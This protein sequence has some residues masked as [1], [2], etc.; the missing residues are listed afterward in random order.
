M[1]K[2]RKRD[3][4]FCKGY[5]V[6]NNKSGCSETNPD[7]FE[8]S[9]RRGP[10]NV[11]KFMYCNDC[12]GGFLN[13]KKGARLNKKRIA[14]L[15]K[16]KHHNKDHHVG[17]LT[18][19]K[20]TKCKDR[21]E[22]GKDKNTESG[23]N[24]QCKSCI[25]G[26]ENVKYKSKSLTIVGKILS[27]L[28]NANSTNNTRNKRRQKLNVKN[29]DKPGYVELSLLKIDIDFDY[30]FNLYEKQRKSC[31]VSG[32][33]LEKYLYHPLFKMSLERIDDNVGYEKGNVVL[34]CL[35][36]NA[37]HHR[38]WTSH[39]GHTIVYDSIMEKTVGENPNDVETLNVRKC[40]KCNIKQNRDKCKECGSQIK[41]MYQRLKD[42]IAKCNKVDIEDPKITPSYPLTIDQVIWLMKKFKWKCE[43][44]KMPLSFEFGSNWT[45]SIDRIDNKKPHT[46]SNIRIV[47]CCMNAIKAA[48]T[49]NAVQIAFKG[50]KSH[51]SE[52]I[53][54]EYP[55]Y[56]RSRLITDYIVDKVGDKNVRYY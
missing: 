39:D 22:F 23:F 11:G 28:K 37:C 1:T 53:H 20:C 10:E 19:T 26:S 3:S 6:D 30:V 24:T 34:V 32:L 46:M 5:H 2:K 55:Y 27:L 35:C 33:D 31:G 54:E 12:V 36:F 43:L 48:W 40:P 15:K 29:K 41:S 56:N 13:D 7:K 47:G 4:I 8:D 16:Y 50:M 21:N 17:N 38:S 14:L 51:T 18:C 45:P 9:R 52:I 42:N 25:N 44:S 49:E